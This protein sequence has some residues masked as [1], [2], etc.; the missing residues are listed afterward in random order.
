MK[1]LDILRGVVIVIVIFMIFLSIEKVISTES[2]EKLCKEYNLEKIGDYCYDKMEN[3]AYPI[4]RYE[5]NI[6]IANLDK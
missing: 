2:E 3:K 1:S 4:I 6:K 5:E